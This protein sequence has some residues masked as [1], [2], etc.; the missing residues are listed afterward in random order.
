MSKFNDIP[1]TDVLDVKTLIHI[2]APL[3]VAMYVHMYIPNH[4]IFIHIVNRE[5]FM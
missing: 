3:H 5:I 2:S 1:I 4:L